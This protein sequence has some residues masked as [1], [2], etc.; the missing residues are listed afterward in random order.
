[1]TRPGSP[2]NDS[3]RIRRHHHVAKARLTR[4]SSTD[5]SA[6][7]VTPGRCSSRRWPLDSREPGAPRPGRTPAVRPR[8]ARDALVADESGGQ[9][10]H[11]TWA[12][13]AHPG[14]AAIP[15]TLFIEPSSKLDNLGV[16]DEAG[17]P[18]V[19]YRTV[20]RR[21]PALTACEQGQAASRV[22]RAGLSRVPSRR[23]SV[24][25]LPG[26]ECAPGT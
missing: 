26:G 3:V 4:A 2:Q 21:L 17:I 23:R 11:R 12:A 13:S 14:G 15:N 9:P 24:L 22:A 25:K 5:C 10:D 1:M 6:D 7:P 16:L 8:Q 18:A 19:S 20:K